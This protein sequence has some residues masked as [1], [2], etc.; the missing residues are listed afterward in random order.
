VSYFERAVSID[1][2]YGT[3]WGALALAYT[4]GL[5]SNMPAELASLPGRIRS[6]A[7]KALQLDEQNADAELALICLPPM[8]RNWAVIEAKLRHLCEKYPRHWLAHGRLAILLYQTGR[9]SDGIP[10]H[11]HMMAID[12]LIAGPYAFCARALSNA[13]RVQE[14]DTLLR[15]GLEK[16]PAHPLLWHA[17]F[18]H[19]LFSGRPEAAAAS[20]MDPALLP[21]GFPQSEV[22]SS[23]QLVRAVD[24]RDTTEVEGV[25]AQYVREAQEDTMSVAY[26]APL[27]S[28]FA[29]FD[30]TFDSLNRYLL[31]RGAFGTPT[32]IGAYGR[33]YTDALFTK[34]M[35][36]ARAHPRFA[37]LVRDVG[38]EAYWRETGSLPDYRRTV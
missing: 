23:L 28:V 4:H 20:L 12:P 8:F 1:A 38:L 33:R 24:A 2:G 15:Q 19:L 14:A 25:V 11:K 6:A 27:F 5:N 7:A 3:A 29:R 26:A 18:N 10:F 37:T 32:P 13:G 31:N 34:P 16:W 36:T 22:E 21:S 17:K 35:E 30:L 9:W